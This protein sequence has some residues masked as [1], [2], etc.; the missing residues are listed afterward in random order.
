MSGCSRRGFLS[1]LAAT[2][3]ATPLSSGAGGA[4]GKAAFYSTLPSLGD[5]DVVVF[6]AGPGGLGAAIRAARAGRRVAFVEKYGFPGGAGVYACTPLFF[7]FEHRGADGWG[8]GF[9]PERYRQIVRGLADETVR[10]LDRA[11]EAWP[12]ADGDCRIPLEKRIGDA[13]LIGKVM[14]RPETISTLYHQMLSEAGVAKFFYAHLADAITDGR[15]VTGAVVSCLEGLRTIR[16]KVFVDATGEAHLVHLAG[17]KTEQADAKFTMHKSA[18][19]FLGGVAKGAVDTYRRMY[20]QIRKDPVA[21]KNIW[22]TPGW[23]FLPSDGEIILPIAYVTGDGCSSADMTRMDETLRKSNQALVRY[24]R[25]H[26]P[27][28]EK[29]HITREATQVGCR[30]GRHIV[31][32][33]KVDIA[34]LDKAPVP[35]NPVVPVWRWW[36]G[37][38]AADQSKGFGTPQSG[39]HAALTAIPYGALVPRSFDNVLVAG[40]DLACDARAITT[41]RM[42]PTCMAMGEAAGEAAAIQCEKNLAD[43]GAVPYGELADR[44]LAAN[45]ILA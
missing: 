10:R 2:G 38:H 33:E 22:A 26:V 43:A 40:R 6:G 1:G 16:A 14:F 31:G 23:T 36:G 41:C 9:H 44:L 34:F 5:F 7:L 12:M 29:A 37:E 30:D 8:G 24:L 25:E 4:G 20:P 13:P 15:R 11:G 18:F 28:F 27:G 35:E 45:A 21:P 17:G 3:L 32:R 42:M 39:Y 19:C